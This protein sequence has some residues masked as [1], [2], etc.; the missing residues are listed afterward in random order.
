MRRALALTCLLIGLYP[1]AHGQAGF[2]SI[3]GRVTDP[4]G[5]VVPGV[6]VF[7]LNTATNIR[8]ESVTNNDG[9][10]QIF[11]LIPGPYQLE[12]EAPNFKRLER[13]GITVQVADKL[14]IDLMLEIG[15]VGET[16]NVTSDAV[17]LRT[18]DAQVGEVITSQNVQNL[19]QVAFGT[20][21]DPLQFLVLAGNVQGSG[22]RA[23]GGSDTRIN[24]GRTQG[25]EYLV[26]GISA[27]SGV[28]REISQSLAPNMDAVAEFKVITNGLAA[29]YGRLSGG[30]VELV[31]K[32]GTN[33]I[34]GQAFWYNQQ[35]GFNAN[36]WENNRLG[37]QKFEYRQNNFGGAVGGP[38]TLPK[39]VFGPAG[40]DGRNRTFWFFNYDGL[41][42]RQAGRLQQG[43]VP[44]V[45]ERQGIFVNT[46]F[47]GIPADIYQ[48]FGPAVQEGTETVRTQPWVTGP[49]DP[50]P[51]CRNQVGKCLPLDQIHPVSQAILNLMPL[52]N[53]PANPGYSM[54]GNYVGVRSEFSNADQWAVRMDH[55]FN[56]NHAIFGRFSRL[57]RDGGS[58]RWRGDLNAAQTSQVKGGFGLSLNYDWSISPTLIFSARVGGHHNPLIAGGRL[59]D[60]FDNSSIP[61]DPVTRA[62]LGTNGMPGISIVGIGDIAD[63]WGGIS[64]R[65]KNLT[66]YNAA[67]SMVKILGRHT[68]KFGY[69]HRR[70]YDNFRQ[71]TVGSFYFI[72]SS[73]NRIVGDRSWQSFDQANGTAAFLY[74][75]NHYAEVNAPYDRASNTNYH[76]AYAQDDWKVTPKLTLGLGV[77]WDGETPTTERYN[78]LYFW[79]NDAP[80]Y[81]QVKP[82]YD[83][84]AEMAKVGFTPAQIARVR[85]PSYLTNG[86]PAGAIRK[87]GTEE[88][89]DRAG[90][91]FYPWQFAPR[92]SVA[93]ALSEK[94]VLRGSFAQMYISTTGDEN[95]PTSA[96]GGIALGDR[97]FNGWHYTN[98]G[99]KT[100]LSNWDNPFNK[101][102]AIT[103]VANDN[104]LA[105]FQA[106]Y[107]E[108]SAAFDRNIRM[109]YELTWSAGIQHQFGN[110]LVVEAY[111]SANLGRNLLGQDVISRFPVDLF[112]EENQDLYRPETTG[113]DKKVATPFIQPISQF[114]EGAIDVGWLQYDRPY[115]GPVYVNGAPVGRSNYQSGN[116]RA[117]YRFFKSSNVLVNYTLSRLLDNVGGPIGTGG[118]T[119]QTFDSVDAIYGLSPLDE[120]HR[121]VISYNFEFPF[122]RGRRFLGSPSTTGGKLLD[123]AV[124][125]W[126]LSG[127]N[128]YRSG[129]PVSFPGAQDNNSLR[130]VNT[131]FSTKT[132]GDDDLKSSG[133]DD[134]RSVLDPSGQLGRNDPRAFDLSKFLL[135]DDGTAGRIGFFPGNLFPVYGGLRNPGYFSSDV[136]LMKK[137]L[138]TGD[139][140]RYFQLRLEGS[141]IFNHPWLGDYQ[142]N[143]KQDQTFGRIIGMRSTER[144]LQVSGRI[145]F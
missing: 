80:S 113:G 25:V 107:G 1:V 137:F 99:F 56:E 141:N 68:A 50:R 4:S 48:M 138:F 61:F 6:K 143:L 43:N 105:N 126:E 10:Y 88:F 46:L 70:Y 74:G 128:T 140:N 115:F 81:W 53:R 118:K 101:P 19:P 144:R 3:S 7:A 133:F 109:P 66:T 95:G 145:V 34:H 40:Y 125:G 22:D 84:R 131:Y 51:Q 75:Y 77:R 87:A 35:P 85:I 72:A 122:G 32:S 26:D 37:G 58:T 17:L 49:N 24:G 16:V 130:I 18:Q 13:A 102:G 15:Q 123:F 44:T 89:P 104:A 33:D 71:G 9:Y 132:P 119:R 47:N 5:A 38:V 129:R 45:E 92:F 112:A 39:S 65:S 121:L 69:E 73:V 42:N 52:P 93:Y 114:P 29:E 91:S 36:S 59:A 110:N 30:A 27:T 64:E 62:F 20:F 134:P 8:V 117:Q 142:T 127:F 57:V 116:F 54:I 23:Q 97:A 120:T 111:Y 31:T 55:R 2:G 108:P 136:S 96:S 135:S 60:D 14:D 139:G 83:L 103:R 21:R 124:G 100:M 86:T 78:K 98:D 11:R 79:D 106:S 76:A 63:P 28:G 94:T 90:Q 41:R 67:A 82:G 12:V